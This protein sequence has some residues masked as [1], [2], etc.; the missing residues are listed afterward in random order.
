MNQPAVLRNA[1]LAAGLTFTEVGAAA[2]LDPSAIGHYEAG[3]TR[4]SPGALERWRDGL[5]R[6]LRERADAIH[7]ALTGI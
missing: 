6:L 4:P 7:H 2:R 1:R 5:S 3:R